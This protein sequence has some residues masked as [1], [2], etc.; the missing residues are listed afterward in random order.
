MKFNC[1]NCRKEYDFMTLRLSADLNAI[2]AMLGTFG[3]HHAVVWAYA[4]LFGV[5]PFHAKAKKLRLILEELKKL[6]DASGFSYQKRLYRIS[7]EGIAEALN[8]VVKKNFADGLDSHNYLK[9]VMINI[10]AREDKDSGRRTE[11][12]LRKKEASLMSGS[13]SING[14]ILPQGVPINAAYPVPE[15]QVEAPRM[16]TMPRIAPLSDAEIEVNRQRLKK[17]A[18]TIG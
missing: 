6:F 13:R 7:P 8:V 4:E 12:D 9:K 3:R 5:V 17:M 18:E 14:D 1:P 10:A 11:K 16:K 15:E 2:I